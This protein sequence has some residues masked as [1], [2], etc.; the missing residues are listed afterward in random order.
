VQKYIGL[1]FEY[2]GYS[3]MVKNSSVNPFEYT[4]GYGGYWIQQKDHSVFAGTE[5]VNSDI[6]GYDEDVN[7]F[8]VTD[9]LTSPVSVPPYVIGRDPGGYYSSLYHEVDAVPYTM[10]SND[11]P[12]VT[13]DGSVNQPIGSAANPIEI[14]AWAPAYTPDQ[15]E[16][17]GGVIA[18]ETGSAQTDCKGMMMYWVSDNGGIF[19]NSGSDNFSVPL[20]S[21]NG[22]SKSPVKDWRIPKIFHNLLIS[23]G[24]SPDPAKAIINT[25][26]DNFNDWQDDCI[27]TFDNT[28]ACN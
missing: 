18:C 20:A 4:E 15:S 2:G 12:V 1:S 28:N 21:A 7:S 22:K 6:T 5:V 17:G 14:L 23:T 10:D 3:G 27:Y 13:Y 26:G 11:R 8:N 19:W 16:D 9:T 24:H 25:D